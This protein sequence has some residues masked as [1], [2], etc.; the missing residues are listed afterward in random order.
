MSSITRSQD[1]PT[2][3]DETDAQAGR[4]RDAQEKNF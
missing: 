3:T 4:I 2:N 1:V